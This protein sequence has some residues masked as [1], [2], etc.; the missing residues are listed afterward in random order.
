MKQNECLYAVL[1]RGRACDSAALSPRTDDAQIINNSSN[2]IVTRT[3]GF[4]KWRQMFQSPEQLSAS[5]MILVHGV[6]VEDNSFLG[7]S[8]CRLV[9]IDRRFG[10]AYCLRH[11][12]VNGGSEHV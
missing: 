8:P 4:R 12:A 5:R 10:D 1:L 7:C 6:P 11:Q 9:E 3:F 2:V